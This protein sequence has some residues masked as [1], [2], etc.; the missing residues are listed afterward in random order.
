MSDISRRQFFGTTVAAAVGA[1]VGITPSIEDASAQSPPAQTPPPVADETLALVNGR[2]HTMD[3]K[4][5]VVTTV[6]IVTAS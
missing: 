4:N 5:T 2:I 6:T 1:G 3:A